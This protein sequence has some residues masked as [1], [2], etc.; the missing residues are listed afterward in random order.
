M[1]RGIR[2]DACQALEASGVMPSRHQGRCL[3]GIGGIRGDAFQ[4]SGA[5]PSRHWG[6]ARGDYDGCQ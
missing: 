5:M 6:I 1:P 2:G 4:A 3:P